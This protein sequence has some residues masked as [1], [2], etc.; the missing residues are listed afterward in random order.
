[1][2]RV[3]E[4][5]RELTRPST[6][7]GWRLGLQSWWYTRDKSRLTFMSVLLAVLLAVPLSIY[8]LIS[9]AQDSKQI[10]RD[11]RCLTQNI[12]HEARGESAAGQYAVAEV[13]LN[14][15]ASRHFPNTV[16][17]VVHEQR[18]DRIR[19]RHVGAFSWTELELKADARDPAYKSARKIAEDV[20]YRRNEPQ[21]EDALFYH[22]SYIQ[23]SWA[24][25]KTK[26]ASIGWHIFY[27]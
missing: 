11:L 1:M 4:K 9:H 19:K 17:K 15:V 20:Y 22:A 13:T 2:Y 25:T 7:Y 10:S 26:V 18:W 3:L 5:L 23:P 12:Y 14:R 21:V 16:C 8:G 6:W 27:K 24:R